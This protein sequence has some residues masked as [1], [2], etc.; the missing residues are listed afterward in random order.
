MDNY[1]NNIDEFLIIPNKFI[2][3]QDINRD[4]IIKIQKI[5][6]YINDI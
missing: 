5:I 4:F 6:F 1:V 3:Y 2:D